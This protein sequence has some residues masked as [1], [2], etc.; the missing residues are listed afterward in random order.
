MIERKKK[1]VPQLRA[2]AR[3]RGV[4]FMMN[5][6]RAALVKRLEDED[7]RDKLLLEAEE[8]GKK[9]LLESQK[10][11]KLSE[12]RH[13]LSITTVNNNLHGKKVE[14][15]VLKKKYTDYKMKMNSVAEELSKANKDLI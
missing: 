7:E 15:E 12:K 14:V 6:T 3:K 10:E 5:W 2:E 9:L 8:K 4:G 1:T 13:D 11:T